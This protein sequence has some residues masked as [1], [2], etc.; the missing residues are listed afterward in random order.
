MAEEPK[1]G[2]LIADTAVSKGGA[3]VAKKLAAR[4]FGAASGAVSGGIGYVAAEVG[5]RA[6]TWINNNKGKAASI[7]G[8]IAAAP[9]I[10]GGAIIAAIGAGLAAL[11]SALVAA[12]IGI[13]IVIAFFFFIINNS[14][15]VVPPGTSFGGGG[16][17][18][19]GIDVG[20]T[21][22]IPDGNLFIG[23]YATG[24]TSYGH[25]EN[26]YWD[27]VSDACGA[28]TLPAYGCYAKQS[29]DY[30]YN[31]GACSVY[32]LAIDVRYPG[33][34]TNS[35]GKPAYL[36]YLK[37]QS[38]QWELTSRAGR[39]GTAGFLRAEVDGQVYE[40]YMSHIQGGPRG[41][42]SGEVAG[43][44]DG[45]AHVHLEL[46]IDG[47]YVNPESMCSGANTN[48]PEEPSVPLPPCKD[49]GGV[50]VSTP[51]CS[52]LGRTTVQGS[53]IEESSDP[54]FICCTAPTS[55]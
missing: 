49:A 52:R 23:V 5:S 50:C 13:P 17:Y 3:A 41:G 19:P 34:Y 43:L 9:F 6:A 55:L 16:G 7:A 37:G 51:S 35:I 29:G 25:G 22:P 12:M 54:S 48:I 24:I 40:I 15:L 10:I 30:C 8:G 47:Q 21:C 38:V 32:G 28:Y 39:T 26:E 45:K 46:R 53:C 18:L 33:P 11:G 4:A 31:L 1:K 27:N 2:N 20:A 14:A 36:P 44:M 42:Q